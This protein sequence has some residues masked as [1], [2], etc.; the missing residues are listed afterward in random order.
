M[1]SFKGELRAALVV[2]QNDYTAHVRIA[3]LFCKEAGTA[4]GVDGLS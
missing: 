3:A 1:P 2:A 4:L